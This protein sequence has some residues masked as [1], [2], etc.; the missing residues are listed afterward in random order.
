MGFKLWY[1]LL[2]YLFH[3][4]THSR[5]FHKVPDIKLEAYIVRI[6]GFY[7]RILKTELPPSRSP[8]LSFVF[9]LGVGFQPFTSVSDFS[10][11]MG[12]LPF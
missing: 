3:S 1:R 8:I 2:N 9:W 6:L 10:M 7:T 5:Q 11:L 4:A 12:L